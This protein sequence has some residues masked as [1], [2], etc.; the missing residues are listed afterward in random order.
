LAL[1]YET[2]V[3]MLPSSLFSSVPQKI[4][5]SQSTQDGP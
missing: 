4:I 1:H 3:G 5:L 2:L